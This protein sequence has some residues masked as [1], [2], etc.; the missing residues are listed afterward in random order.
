MIVQ[1][2][3]FNQDQQEIIRKIYQKIIFKFLSFAIDFKNFYCYNTTIVT[4]NCHTHTAAGWQQRLRQK[5]LLRNT[6]V[7]QENSSDIFPLSFRE[8]C[9]I[10]F[11]PPL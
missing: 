7:E 4:S 1:I 8:I 11:A 3:F 5:R 2:A 10:V 9:R 6:W